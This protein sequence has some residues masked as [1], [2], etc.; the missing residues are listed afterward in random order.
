MDAIPAAVRDEQ[1]RCG[2][3]GGRYERARLAL[4]AATAAATSAS[5]PPT[6][7]RDGRR[8]LPGR[9]RV[10]LAALPRRR[11]GGGAGGGVD[12]PS[13]DDLLALLLPLLILLSTLLFLLLLF[14][15]LVLLFRRRA[16][17]IQ[18]GADHLGPADIT[19]DAEATNGALLL[20]N[21]QGYLQ[22]LAEQ[23]LRR[24]YLR[25][26]EWAL[27]NPAGSLSTDI[28]LS[29]FL[30]IQEKG[31][32]AW[33]FDPDYESNP[34]VFVSARTEITFLAD[35]QG[36]APEEGGGC[37]VQSNLPL[38]KLNEVY[39]WEVKMFDKP[40]L[41]N[42]AVGLS[43]RPYPSFRLPGEWLHLQSINAISSS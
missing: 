33:S 5:D 20:E 36:M 7:D 19:R 11:S 21:E 43:T 12:L 41:T 32:S 25:A 1:S 35:G 29:Q 23:P 22:G 27:A 3:R 10:P 42:V 18:L 16:R 31:V 2:R 39:Y 38:P 17:R 6:V 13:E 8:A 9:R 24:G 26:K 28:T 40:D 37:C 30:S 15:I 14:T 34:S 4:A